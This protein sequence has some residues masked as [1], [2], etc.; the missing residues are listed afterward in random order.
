MCIVFVAFWPSPEAGQNSGYRLVLASNRD[1]EF[2]RPA[3]CAHAWN[4]GSGVVAGMD[5]T[6]GK[7]GGTWIGVNERNGRFGVI[8]NVRQSLADIRP[9]ARGRGCLVADFLRS[10]QTPLEYCTMLSERAA[11]F[12]AF[13]ILL[14]DMSTGCLCYY[15][16]R[17]GES[18]RSLAPG[19]Y[20]LSNA[21]LDTPWKKVV[22]GKECFSS[23]LQTARV[24]GMAE[25]ELQQRLFGLLS[26]KTKHWPD[27]LMQ[28][29]D[30]PEEW[31]RDLSSVC[32][33]CDSVAYGT[34]AKSII[35]VTDD[36]QM[37]FKETAMQSPIQPGQEPVWQTSEFRFPVPE[38]HPERSARL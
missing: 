31:L 26:D 24:D 21:F 11:E 32:V 10:E 23:L 19:I 9:D 4:D 18:P 8:T 16:N 6:P 15:G 38:S 12:N 33:G 2:G 27:P 13:N 14:G 5:M 29:D 3:K 36:N 28:A 22:A 7:E 25:D 20:G 37:L 34:R 35:V 1:E 17:T 30:L